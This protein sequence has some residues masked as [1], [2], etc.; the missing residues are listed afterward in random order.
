MELRFRVTRR[1]LA[2]V[3]AALAVVATGSFAW[4]A[5]GGGGTIQGCVTNNGTIDAIDPVTQ[6]CRERQTPVEWYTK[7]GADTAFLGRAAKA[8]DSDKLDGLDSSMFLGVNAKAA[9]ADSLDGIDSSAFVRGNVRVSSLT[10][11]LAP[12]SGSQE[13]HV[14]SFGTAPLAVLSFHCMNESMWG[15]GGQL[16]FGSLSPVR[17]WRDD[18]GATPTTGIHTP[19]AAMSST[20]RAT[21]HETWQF[22]HPDDGRATTVEVW[23]NF[24]PASGECVV[25]VTGTVR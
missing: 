3:V 7:S 23:W 22:R 14:F 10:A 16:S 17:W 20:V 4:A 5:V 21:A 12:A 8:A 13:I 18:G 19:G 9:D 25:D 11:T 6:A 1:R 2:F 15:S 24:D